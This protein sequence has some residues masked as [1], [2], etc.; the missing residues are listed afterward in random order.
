MRCRLIVYSS[1]MNNF[2]TKYTFYTKSTSPTSAHTWTHVKSCCIFTSNSSI[3]KMKTIQPN[4]HNRLQK[5]LPMMWFSDLYRNKLIIIWSILMELRTIIRVVMVLL[6]GRS[7]WWMI[8]MEHRDQIKP[9]LNKAWQL[10]VTSNPKRS[11]ITTSKE[12]FW[13]I[14]H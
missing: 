1:W 8:L 5:C 14:H 13:K 2:S 9:Y 7:I 3:L 12:L 4:I 10:K 11:L 6:K